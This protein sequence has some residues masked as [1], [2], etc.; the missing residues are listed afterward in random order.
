VTAKQKRQRAVFE[1]LRG[2]PDPQAVR[3]DVHELLQS[4]TAGAGEITLHG[5]EQTRSFPVNRRHGLK[6]AT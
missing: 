4:V 5:D 6:Y 2:K 1:Q 3:K